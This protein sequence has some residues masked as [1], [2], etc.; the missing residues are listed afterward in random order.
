MPTP[1]LFSRLVALAATIGLIIAPM[2]SADQGRRGHKDR[3]DYS[4]SH[5][6]DR[7]RHRSNNHRG[8]RDNRQHDKRQYRRGHGD[9]YPNRHT[10]RGHD[11]RPRYTHSYATNG[12]AYGPHH[13]SQYRPR[14]TVGH[15]YRP[16]R[17]TVYI[18]DYYSH[19]LYDPPRG[20]H[21]VRDRDNGDAVLASVATGAIIGLVIGALAYN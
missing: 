4:R 20:Y 5:H 3:G 2:A 18:N 1:K 12:R 11:Y 16:H 7:A 21:W 8:Y 10:R 13:R 15:Y 6:N 14:Y 19:G 17:Q 9:Y